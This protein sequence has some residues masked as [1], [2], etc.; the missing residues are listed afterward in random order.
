MEFVKVIAVCP[1]KGK[2]QCRR[3]PVMYQ[4]PSIR[5]WMFLST[6]SLAINSQQRV[7]FFRLSA[8]IILSVDPECRVPWRAAHRALLTKHPAQNVSIVTPPQI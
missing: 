2:P 4:W 5:G 3:N 8:S 7:H 1:T 6:F